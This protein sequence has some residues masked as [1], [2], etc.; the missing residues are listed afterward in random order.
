MN[1]GSSSTFSNILVVLVRLPLLNLF[2]LACAQCASRTEAPSNGL[3]K[4]HRRERHDGTTHSHVDF[5]NLIIDIHPTLNSEYGYTDS[6][7]GV[8]LEFQCLIAHKEIYRKV[9]RVI[10]SRPARG[11]ST[12]KRI[13]LL[14]DDSP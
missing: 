8:S 4:Y 14:T 1:V 6:V 11:I 9:G 12:K 13:F 7:V 2:R 5:L 3:R 10:V